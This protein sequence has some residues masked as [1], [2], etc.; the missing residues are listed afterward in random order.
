MTVPDEISTRSSVASPPD[1]SA[2]PPPLSPANC[3]SASTSAQPQPHATSAGQ[4]APPAQPQA[5]ATSDR[6]RA[7]RKTGPQRLSSP[8]APRV[9]PQVNEVA[10]H[11]RCYVGHAARHIV[12]RTIDM[13]NMTH[14]KQLLAPRSL[15]VVLQRLE[16][17]NLH[18][19]DAVAQT[20]NILPRDWDRCNTGRRHIRRCKS[21]GHTHTTGPGVLHC[22]L[23]NKE[24]ARSDRPS[25]S[26]FAPS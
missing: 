1:C 5:H 13:P 17:T 21:F 10:S 22:T 9:G 25:T 26:H 6:C 14:R 7:P 20:R 18:C 16:A 4:L 15:M 19:F 3:R 11:S 23:N 8:P 24:T 2:T 12:K